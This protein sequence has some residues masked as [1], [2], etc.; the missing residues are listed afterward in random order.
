[1][2]FDDKMKSVIEDT[3]ALEAGIKKP[4]ELKKEVVVITLEGRDALM[5]RHLLAPVKDGKE[6]HVTQ[7]IFK[8][9][10]KEAGNTIL[11]HYDPTGKFEK[12]A[13]EKKAGAWQRMVERFSG[14]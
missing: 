1:M 8:M 9:G 6:H 13:G 7:L 10:M 2:T 14:K 12:K 3:L 11:K 4:D 5:L